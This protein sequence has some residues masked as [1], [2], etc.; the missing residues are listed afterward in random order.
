[1]NAIRMLAW[2]EL[3]RRARQT[4][5]LML[6]I[7]VVGAI[8]LA[9]AAGARRSESALQRFNAYSR[10]ADVE[11][12]VGSPSAAQLEAFAHTP[13]IAAIGA[14]EA[15]PLIVPQQPSLAVM[16]PIDDNF[17]NV[18][19]R[20]RLVAGRRQ[21]PND[22]NEITI[23]EGLAARLR[24]APGDV[25]DATALTPDQLQTALAGRDPG[26]SAGTR[27]CLRVV[28]I[29]RRPLDLGD[30]AAA[31]G[32]AVLSPA[33]NQAYAGRAGRYSLVLRVR[34]V[35]G[36]AD[37]ANVTAAAR[38]IF[39]QSPVFRVQPLNIETEGA[40]D[41]INVLAR[42]LWIFAAVVA[43]AGFVIIAIM[44]ARF[45]AQTTADQSPLRALGL[46]RRERVIVGVPQA[47]TIAVG[48]ALIAIA[49]ALAASPL[50]PVGLARRADPD[51][52]L[53]ADWLVLVLGFCAI[54]AG[55]A[56]LWLLF[57]VRVTRATPADA[58]AARRARKASVVER[59]AESGLQPTMANGFRIAFRPEDSAAT[60]PIRPA[61][62]GAALGVLGVIAVIVFAAS[63]DHLVATPR[64]Y[65]W[66]FD[67]RIE[68]TRVFPSTQTTCPRADDG[69]ST[70]AGITD[71]GAVCTASVEV[72]GHPA[73]GWGF[74]QLRGT[75]GPTIG[76]GR[77][78]SQAD[79]V[80]LGAVT[81][82]TI[83]KRIGE[84]VR[85][86]GGGRTGNYTIVGQAV[87]PTISSGNPQPLA[88]G[89]VFTNAGQ[90]RVF[91]PNTA[92]R[93]LIGRLAPGAEPA[94]A[95][96]VSTMSFGTPRLGAW[97]DPGL[98][99]RLTVPPE[100]ERIQQIDWVL[101]TLALLLAGLALLGVGYALVTSARNRR[102]ELAVLKTLGF[103]RRQV[104]ATVAWQATTYAV[105]GL[106]VGIP[107][108]LVVGSY[109]W[110]LV[111]DNL[112]VTSAPAVPLVAILVAVPVAVLSV[113]AIAFFP[114]RAAARIRP[115]VALATE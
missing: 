56:L 21:N 114:A 93:F 75:I 20:S 77:A 84:T 14:G 51:P 17:G 34:T 91:D 23:G 52:G 103:D 39:G 37:V 1:V 100:V 25:L 73:S 101:P 40:R 35:H 74:T 59:V 88:D 68:D 98:Q 113:N 47:L 28:G 58:A 92:T 64:Q 33:F 57:A 112:G 31:G 104:R 105:I 102:R 12:T 30:R 69:L 36:N 66:T 32:L 82:R 94:V 10:S 110:R 13:G 67:F 61:F 99:L 27:V 70:V 115:S 108:G 63:L 5:V 50:F 109:A 87:L 15:Y 72:N 4:I 111:A 55:V 49:V 97:S 18:V 60:V 44:L 71:V 29:V 86:N 11:L 107:L 83:H 26:S 38:K 16:A 8:V 6:L 95:R 89:A 53:H 96:R 2:V 54:A 80:A 46:T 43:L 3:R 9:T 85:I 19:D 81:M 62:I 41:A 79:E 7:G 45:T 48:G 24:V 78:P 106:V 42:A 65:G 76:A 90:A 22:P